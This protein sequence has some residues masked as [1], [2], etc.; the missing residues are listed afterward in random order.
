MILFFCH[1]RLKY[2]KSENKSEIEFINNSINFYGKIYLV[3]KN[4]EYFNITFNNNQ[5]SISPVLKEYIGTGNNDNITYTKNSH[6]HNVI[7]MLS[8]NDI[9][10]AKGGS[11]IV[12]DGNGN[13]NDIIISTKGNNIIDAGK[14]D[15]VIDIN[16]TAYN[17]K[18]YLNEGNNK[19]FLQGMDNAYS[20]EY[21]NDNLILSSVES[22]RK[23]TI[24]NYNKYKDNLEINTL[25]NNGLVLDD[26]KINLLVNAASAFKQNDYELYSTMLT[27]N[28]KIFD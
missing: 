22:E 5:Y 2:S 9:I 19:I 21:K 3:D 4:N 13:G 15:N 14:G 11:N 12:V 28:E 16:Y 24:Y 20:Q 25:L 26:A 17:I 27:T 1:N 7:R 10:T 18:V 8:G 23:I 6:H